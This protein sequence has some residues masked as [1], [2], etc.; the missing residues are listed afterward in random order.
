MHEPYFRKDNRVVSETVSEN[1]II[2]LQLQ[3]NGT[4]PLIVSNTGSDL[5]IAYNRGGPWFTMLDGYQYSWENRHP[6][7]TEVYVTNLTAVT[8][9][10]QFLIG[11]SMYDKR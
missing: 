11:G 10:I 5:Q 8:S 2:V 4:E 3:T 1:E 9:T 6:F 7:N